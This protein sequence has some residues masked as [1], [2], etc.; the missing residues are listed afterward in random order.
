MA[1][2]DFEAADEGYFASVSDLMVGILFVFLLVLTVFALNFRDAEDDQKHALDDAEQQRQVSTFEQQNAKQKEIEADEQKKAN[3]YLQ[4]LLQKAVDQMRQDAADRQ[5][6]L[7]RLLTTLRDRLQKDGVI[8][9]I[10]PNSGV[11]RLPEQLLF[12]KG[13]RSLEPTAAGTL[14][15][16]AAALSDVLPCF[17]GNGHSATCGE[18]DQPILEGVLVEGHSDHQGYRDGKR[19][20]SSEESRDRND[21]LSTER[22][23]S[24]FKELLKR[25]GLDAL[26]NSNNLPLLA[27]SAYGDRRP[28]AAGETQDDFQKNR[29]IDLRFLL[30]PRTSRDLQKLIDEITPALG[31]IQ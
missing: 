15:I 21:Q 5:N 18:S 14:Q 4:T 25:N 23:L 8:I 1:A 12:A 28:I 11:L 26:R 3:L 22:S 27:V 24:V 17:A 20:L 10:D 6:A 29:R 9:S 13:S 30:S 19:A 31:K 2:G 16:L 7:E